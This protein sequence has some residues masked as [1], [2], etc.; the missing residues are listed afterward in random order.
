MLSS[1]INS[2]HA[3][4]HLHNLQPT[5]F[6]LTIAL[7]TRTLSNKPI[8][9]LPL[10]RR[11]MVKSHSQLLHKS[12]IHQRIASLSLNRRAL[13]QNVQSTRSIDSKRHVSLRALKSN[14]HVHI[15]KRRKTVGPQQ[16]GLAAGD[17]GMREVYCNVISES[18]DMKVREAYH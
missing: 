9:P 3:I 18:H 13:D 8:Q 11:H 2:L 1:Y 17:D 16:A 14:H 12:I 10:A 5:T 15:L 6:T 4:R 7:T